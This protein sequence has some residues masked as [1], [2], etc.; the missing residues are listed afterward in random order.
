MARKS[1]PYN[2]GAFET[3][4]DTWNVADGYVK[5]KI[6]KLMVELDNLETIARF[7]V[8]S[9]DE[10]HIFTHDQI[11]QRR[12]NALERYLSLILQLVGNVQ[13]S[14]S[15]RNKAKILEH[16]KTAEE[17]EDFI[18]GAWSYSTN[19]IT[20]DQGLKINEKH[21]RIC[22]KIL[23]R[24]KD[25]INEPINKAG[26]IFRQSSEIDLDKIMGEIVEGG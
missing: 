22:L 10:M 12:K 17:V 25:D 8:V 11:L 7:G 2:E 24:I 20:H 14:L 5:L 9:M 4:S 13:F 26:L 16:K 3:G 15:K 19:Q 21:F 23:T 18:D 6:L 1:D